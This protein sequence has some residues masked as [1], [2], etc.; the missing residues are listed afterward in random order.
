MSDR[1]VTFDFPFLEKQNKFIYNM[2]T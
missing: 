2:Y 1:I